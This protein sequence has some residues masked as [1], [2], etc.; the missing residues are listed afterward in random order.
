MSESKRLCFFIAPIG[1]SGS[2]T[3]RRSDD[4]LKYIV[5]PACE[6]CGYDVVRADELDTPGIIT[7]RVIGLLLGANVVVVD[8]TGNNP[9]VFYELGIRHSAGLPVV[10]IL[11]EGARLPFD[12]SN[13][14]TIFFDSSSLASSDQCRH[15][16][17]RHIR[18]TED[19]GVQGNPVT[20][21]LGKAIP[22]LATG[23]G[24]TDLVEQFEKLSE[25]I[26]QELKGIKADRQAIFKD[27]ESV[28]TEKVQWKNFDDLSG[29]WASNVGPLLIS[30]QGAQLHGKYE[31]APSLAPDMEHEVEIDVDGVVWT[32]EI[33]GKILDELVVFRWHWI[34]NSF[35]GTGFWS[36]GPNELT[37]GW[38]YNWE[39]VP[40]DE[41]LKNPDALI[42]KGV[43]IDR[44]W[45]AVRGSA[46]SVENV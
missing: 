14:N 16:L 1:E 36:I 7:D 11:Q 29:L 38:F 28:L 33:E 4:V 25:R 20:S 44:E 34:N 17:V 9:N 42:S 23:G 6:E 43:A 19:G 39:S 24:K 10:Q 41:A 15:R 12:I 31:F 2:D 30:Q 37:G 5:R 32:G 45:F 40:Y 18:S 27:L 26:L 8:L 22:I 46:R 3:R 21:Y 13:L 35:Y